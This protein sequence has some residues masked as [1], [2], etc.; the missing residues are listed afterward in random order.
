M[1]DIIVN[2]DYYTKKLIFVNTKNEK[3][4]KIRVRAS[5]RGEVYSFTAVQIRTKFKKL[6]S[7]CKK[8]ALTIKS[9]TGI[10]RF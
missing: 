5:E 3:N 6:V 1:V 4:T 2:N 9:A 8:A 7:E 10:K